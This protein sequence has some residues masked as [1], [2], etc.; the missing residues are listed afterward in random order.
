VI[1]REEVFLFHFL[2]SS[3]VNGAINRGCVVVVPVEA[4]SFSSGKSFATSYVLFS[5]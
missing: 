3:G 2:S 5:S 1:C 4:C